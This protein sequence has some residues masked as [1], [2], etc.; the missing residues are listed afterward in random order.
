ME[1]AAMAG[2][3]GSD[4]IHELDRSFPNSP[5]SSGKK[6][7]GKGRLFRQIPSLPCGDILLA[8][9]LKERTHTSP[10]ARKP[11]ASPAA[12]SPVRAQSNTAP[13][14]TSRPFDC[15]LEAVWLW[16]DSMN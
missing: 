3:R 14:L 1:A 5:N 7:S 2:L 15:W 10:E 4:G 13:A 11:V 6:R 16:F 12:T 8:S 9:R